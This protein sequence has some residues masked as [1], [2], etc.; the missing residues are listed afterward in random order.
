MD[1]ISLILAMVSAGLLV[2]ATRQ[3]V[4]FNRRMPALWALL[5]AR[6]RAHRVRALRDE[7]RTNVPAARYLYDSVDFDDP[8]IRAL[9]LALKQMHRSGILSLLLLIVVATATLAVWLIDVPG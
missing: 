6:Q 5:E 8:E 3:I 2:H 1:G 4:R 9:K 7:A